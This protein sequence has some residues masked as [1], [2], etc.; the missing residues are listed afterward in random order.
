M[1]RWCTQVSP[2]HQLIAV[3]QAA[4]TRFRRLLEKLGLLAA[5]HFVE[6]GQE[7]VL[8]TTAPSR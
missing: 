6:Y 4:N 7:Q 1:L 3:T 8:Y 2:D 5:D